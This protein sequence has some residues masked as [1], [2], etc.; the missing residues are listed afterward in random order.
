MYQI[1]RF[2]FN[3]KINDKPKEYEIKDFDKINNNHDLANKLKVENKPIFNGIL[4][5]YFNEIILKIFKVSEKEVIDYPVLPEF[6]DYNENL[7]DNENIILKNY[8]KCPGDKK[9]DLIISILMNYTIIK[10]KNNAERVKLEYDYNIEKIRSVFNCLNKGGELFIHFFNFD[11]RNIK[12]LHIL[13]L[14]FEKIVLIHDVL[15]CLEF[16]P[17]INSK[18]FEDLISN[19]DKLSFSPTINLSDLNQYQ[20]H[21]VKLLLDIIN[22]FNNKKY[23]EFS[24]NIYD[25]FLKY[26]EKFKY[27]NKDPL[28]LYL[29]ENFKI[30]TVSDGKKIH[31][32]IKP[33]EGKFLQN[34]IISNNLSKCLEIG[35]AFGISAMYIT[36]ALKNIKSQENKS[37]ISIDPNQSTQW[38]N[39]GVNLLKSIKTNKMHK[40]YE[41]KSYNILPLLLKE[42]K[43]FD[44]IFIDGWH[45]FDYTL[46][47]FFYASLLLEINGYIIIDDALHSGV[48]KCVK[49]IE[50]N[51]KH[52]VRIYPSPNTVA[53]F[54]KLKDDDRDWNYHREF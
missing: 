49:Y 14:L 37:L 20:N 26:N 24:N 48:N 43:K 27:N 7:Y 18:K 6:I 53:V 8:Y 1:K 28:D 36:L 51:Y 17:K 47:D 46:L 31:S 50:T 34:I 3:Y 5:S 54:K 39:S 11:S 12:L 44:F 40:L 52:F 32:A 9:Y 41:D 29:F 23:K 2:K 4:Y 22:N 38:K 10:D 21:F 35:M 33:E 13:L 16:N 25:Y 19:I 42:N 45:T 15:Y 30:N